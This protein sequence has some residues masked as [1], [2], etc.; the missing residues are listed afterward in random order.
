MSSNRLAWRLAA[1]LG[2]TTALVAVLLTLYYSQTLP[3]SPLVS[4]R[5]A[6]T[7]ET[8]ESGPPPASAETRPREIPSADP[9]RRHL[10]RLIGYCRSLVTKQRSFVV[11][12]NGTCVVVNEPSN[13]PV[14]NALGVLK[15]CAA[16]DARFIT[17]KVEHGNYL[18]TYSQPA[19]NCM[20][21]D[22][23]ESAR[24]EIEHGYGAFLTT[25]E[26][27]QMPADWNPP[28]HAKL[29]VIA[30]TRMN[31]DANALRVAK[32]IRAA[33]E[34]AASTNALLSPMP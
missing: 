5:S 18:V 30:R 25:M 22:E 1:A 7:A 26:K 2:A 12:A 14:S 10:D 13:N 34:T 27:Q 4:S 31:A 11:F 24:E 8:R 9:P 21:W 17:T 15:R 28:F 6:S 20:F 19:F 32:V 23:V 3:E 29:G 16:P 33:P